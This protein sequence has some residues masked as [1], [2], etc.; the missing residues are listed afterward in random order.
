MLNRRKTKKTGLDVILEVAG[1]TMGDLGANLA[2]MFGA[3]G[4]EEGGD[5]DASDVQEI[6][7]V[8]DGEEGETFNRTVT[9]KETGGDNLQAQSA[10][11]GTSPSEDA[12]PTH[13]DSAILTALTNIIASY[14][15]ETTKQEFNWQ[16]NYGP[17][18]QAT[19]KEEALAYHP[20][21]K[22]FGLVQKGSPFVQLVHSPGRYVDISAPSS[23]VGKS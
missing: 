8:P 16:P 9:F 18:N 11:A 10:A 2:N 13:Q 19:F 22:M 17:D 6:P 7:I 4:A 20:R 1:A 3:E 21:L 15:K 14:S 23:M 5:E 12:P